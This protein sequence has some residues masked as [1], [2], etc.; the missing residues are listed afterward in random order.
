MA[1]PSVMAASVVSIGTVGIRI[2]KGSLVRSGVTPINRV[3]FHFGFMAK[4]FI[5]KGFMA[6]IAW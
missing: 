2:L 3:W 1:H 6:K 4:V 5:A